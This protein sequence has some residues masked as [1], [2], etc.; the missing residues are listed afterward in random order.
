MTTD[1]SFKTMIRSGSVI[2]GGSDSNKG[3]LYS[4]DNGKTWKESNIT[5]G[6]FDSLIRIGSTIIAGSTAYG[7]M[8]GQGLLYSED[9]GKT[10][11][12]SNITS[13][14]F[15]SLTTINSIIIAG[16][17]S[18]N[19]LYYSEDKGKTW[20]QSNINTGDFNCLT[21]INNTVIASSTTVYDSFKLTRRG[22]NKGLYYSEDNGK[23]WIQSNINFGEFCCLTTIGST[24]IAGSK[25]GNGL[26]YSEDKGKT[27]NR[28]NIIFGIF[29][30]LTVIGNTIIA[31]SGEIS[32]E[33]LYYSEDNGKTWKE[34]NITTG[35]FY[36]LTVIGDTVIAGSYSRNLGKGLYYSEDNGKTWIQSNINDGRFWC[37]LTDGSKV[38]A[39]GRYDGNYR[40]NKISDTVIAGSGSG[41]LCSEDKGHTWINHDAITEDDKVNDMV[42]YMNDKEVCDSNI[43]KN[44]VIKPMTKSGSIVIAGSWSNKGLYYSED[45]G[46]TWNES[47]IETGNFSSLTTIG[48]TVIAGSDSDKGLWYSEDNGKTWN[49]SNIIS[50]YFLCLTIIG[51]TVIA[52]SYSDKGLY[53]SEDNGKTWKQSNINEGHFHCLT[54][55]GSTV[56][57]GGR[58]LLYSDDKGKT[59]KHSNIN[60]GHTSSLIVIGNTVIANGSHDNKNYS[61]Y[62]EDNGH[63]WR[64]YD[65][66]IEDDNV[67]DKEVCDSNMSKEI[68]TTKKVQLIFEFDKNGDVLLNDGMCTTIEKDMVS[69]KFNCNGY[70]L[71]KRIVSNLLE[72][73]PLVIDIVNLDN[74]ELG[75]NIISFSIGFSHEYIYHKYTILITKPSIEVH[76]KESDKYIKYVTSVNNIILFDD[77]SKIV[78]NYSVK[79]DFKE[80]NINLKPKIVEQYY[81]FDDCNNIEV[82]HQYLLS[83]IINHCSNILYD[84]FYQKYCTK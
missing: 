52:G 50:G 7:F 58:G 66:I 56:I 16:S 19:G 21:V 44:D 65:D 81:A 73:L 72:S 15:W 24:V 46:K 18:D 33:G 83:E 28:S 26:F 32:G 48:D 3:L 13:G 39:S 70:D 51:S 14:G 31:G 67:N 42:D 68:E 40:L 25:S 23:T 29:K 75:K 60:Y 22:S 10:W 78:K 55:I 30:C 47:N 84:Y 1:I 12:Q 76:I 2:V 64:N 34:S 49:K 63:T 8:C 82:K 57:A 37:L 41:L 45:N 71:T 79:G 36:C 80:Y 20:N 9:N 59:W 27:W 62:S 4:E 38:F 35:V 11:N 5:I 6:V 17:C 74:N 61:L 77:F 54:T 69:I 43:S 53:Y